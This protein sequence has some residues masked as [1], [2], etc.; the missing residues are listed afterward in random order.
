MT[1]QAYGMNRNTGRAIDSKAH[2]QQSISDILTTPKGSRLMRPE[3][4]SDLLRM[5]DRPVNAEF[6]A[7][8]IAETA[9]AL[10]RWEPRI[11]VD[12]VSVEI[13]AGRVTIS[14]DYVDRRTGRR[15]K[16]EGLIL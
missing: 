3:Y 10:I 4:G 7:D 13:D 5:T 8:V 14:L 15:E 1:G 2:L 6:K 11:K 16:L 9:A 12:S